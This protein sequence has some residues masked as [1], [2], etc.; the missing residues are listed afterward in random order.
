[1]IQHN[2]CGHAKSRLRKHGARNVLGA[3]LAL[4]LVTAGG[5]ANAALRQVTNCNDSGSGSLRA[6]ITA[7]M[8]GDVVDATGLTCSTISL[9]TGSLA[10][11]VNNLT[12]VGAGSSRLTVK[13]GAK[14]GRVFRHAGTGVLSLEGMTITGGMV[15]SIAT[16]AGTQ[17]GCIYSKGTVNLGN[18][19]DA[20]DWTSGVVVSNCTAVSTQVSVEARGGAIYAKDGVMLTNSIVKQGRAI[21]QAPA[22]A[23]RGGGISTFKVRLINSVISGNKATGA[24]S[25][26]GGLISGDLQMRYSEISDN[27][28]GRIGGFST[29]G[30][31]DTDV[32]IDSSTI[33]GNVSTNPASDFK[34]A[35]GALIYGRVKLS[36]T[37]I[38]NNTSASVA[39][40]NIIPFF[41]ITGVSIIGCTI[42]GNTSSTPHFGAGLTA[43]DLSAAFTIESTIISGNFSVGHAPSDLDIGPAAVSGSHN[44]VGAHNGLVP[45]DTL[46]GVD[47]KL[48]PLANNGGITRTHLLLAGS[49]AID[50][51]S[52]SQQKLRDQRGVGFPRVRGLSAD[53]GATESDPDRIF[54]NGFE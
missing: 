54:D 12:V 31:I 28:A 53:I 39:G 19:S 20:S 23:A 47:P 15:S 10:V 32:V 50:N 17:G 41:N 26:A 7:S 51:G 35:G 48:G 36:Q 18:P 46:S 5:G 29:I 22:V 25:Y 14:Y 8:S 16:E 44:L 13:N 52:N 49:P 43:T 37:T 9:N 3:A 2:E 6:A 40:I 4:A 21:A 1:M 45:V 34:D 24:Y 33:S 42:T 38:S 27:T 11:T 30:S